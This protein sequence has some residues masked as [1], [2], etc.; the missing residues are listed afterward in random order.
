MLRVMSQIVSDLEALDTGGLPFVLTDRET[1]ASVTAHRRLEWGAPVSSTEYMTGDSTLDSHEADLVVHLRRNGLTALNW[2]SLLD[3]TA[4]LVRSVIDGRVAWPEGVQDVQVTG[5]GVNHEDEDGELTFSVAALI[6]HDAGD[7]SW[8]APLAWSGPSSDYIVVEITQDVVVGSG[9]AKVG[10]VA[11]YAGD[12]TW[13]ISG[14]NDTSTADAATCY[15][16]LR[17][18]G[19][20]VVATVSTTS[21]SATDMSA[22]VVVTAADTFSIYVYSS[23]V[24][25]VARVEA[26]SLTRG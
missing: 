23:A 20:S 5:S 10:E 13:D 9:A 14:W 7:D 26:S 4:R 6:S 22:S 18:S 11:L 3:S 15:F 21:T 19:G 25:G 1:T 12:W 24:T 17:D 8:S 16:E 2:M